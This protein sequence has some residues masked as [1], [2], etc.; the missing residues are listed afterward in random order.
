MREQ[1]W[2]GL[3]RITIRIGRSRVSFASD[4]WKW[5]RYL[6]C[7]SHCLGHGGGIVSVVTLLPKRRGR[8]WTVYW[9]DILELVMPSLRIAYLCDMPPSDRNIYS[10]GNAR[11]FDALKDHA[12]SVTVLPQD[13]GAAEPLRQA[14]LKTSTGMNMRLRWR[15]HY[16]LRGIIARR[17]QRA[18]QAGTYDV[19]FGTYALHAM[20]GVTA[21]K[22]M[23]TAFTADALQSVFRE[24]VLGTHHEQRLIGR[25]TNGWVERRE[26][27]ALQGLDLGLWPSEWL[28][29]A[30]EARYNLPADVSHVV[31]WGANIPPPPAPA[32][33]SLSSS[34]RLLVIGR[35]W[36]AKGGPTAFDTMQI[37]RARGMDARLTV[38]GCI[39]PERYR[40][41]HVTVHPQLNKAVPAELATFQNALSEAHFLV[42]PSFESY[43]FAFCEA[44]AYGLPALCLRVGGVPVREGENGHA[45][46]PGSGPEDFADIIATYHA[47]PERYADLSRSARKVY[48]Q[49]LNWDAWARRSTAL[50]RQAVAEKRS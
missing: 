26:R 12:D 9:F 34:V 35:D 13:W 33:R 42:M 20:A 32:P 19:L 23:V 29:D 17:V 8:R 28:R 49:R 31:E 43:G 22:G 45:L 16:A 47:A 14:I 38:I 2:I 11:I 4:L 44:S 24:S 1:P 39:P 40:S 46:P 48:E 21:P 3:P 36:F 30:V 41:D 27:E 5:K 18:L 7:S 10:G 37:L 25:V 50:M 15:A 6:W